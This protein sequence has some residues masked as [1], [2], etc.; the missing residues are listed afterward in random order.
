MLKSYIY[1]KYLWFTEIN[2]R[3]YRAWYG[4]GVMYVKVNIPNYAL[5][6]FSLARNLRPR[7]SNMLLALGQAFDL[8]DHS[9]DALICYY[10]A[11]IYDKDGSVFVKAARYVIQMFT[12]F[13]Y[14]VRIFYN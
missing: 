13:S 12:N 6:Y 3:D 4:L 10:R 9:Y 1:F 2:P 8:I 14:Y 7:D 5:H 11:L